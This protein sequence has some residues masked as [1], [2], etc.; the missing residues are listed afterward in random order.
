MGCIGNPDWRDVR[1]TADAAGDQPRQTERI[2]AAKGFAQCRRSIRD[3]GSLGPD[4][5][6]HGTI[7]TPE[8][9]I[10]VRAL[11]AFRAPTGSLWK[12]SNHD[13]VITAMRMESSLLT[14]A[15]P[16]AT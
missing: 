6:I 14:E 9:Q 4:R 7:V 15:I 11:S 1:L 13:W 8:E 5:A 3:R 16:N 10:A 12:A 2:T